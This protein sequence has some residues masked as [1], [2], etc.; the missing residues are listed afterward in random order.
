MS[1]GFSKAG[2]K[3]KRKLMPID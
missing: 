3:Q 2:L 1:N